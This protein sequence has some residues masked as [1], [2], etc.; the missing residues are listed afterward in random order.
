MDISGLRSR[1][2]V[3]E[4]LKQSDLILAMEPY[5]KEFVSLFYPFLDDQIF[6]LGAW[7]DGAAS[8]KAAIKDPVGGTIKTYRKAFAQLSKHIDRIIPLLRS[9]YGY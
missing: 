4:E 5:H 8:R 3:P 9:E 2:L 1:P 6:L 7:P